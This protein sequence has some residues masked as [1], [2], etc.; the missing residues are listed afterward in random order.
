MNQIY[1]TAEGYVLPCC[2]IGNE[3]DM[4]EY[5]KWHG[6][7]L[8]EMSLKNRN[9]EDILKDPRYLRIEKSWERAEPFAPCRWNC[10][11][12]L[13][14]SWEKTQGTNERCSLILGEIEKAKVLER[15]S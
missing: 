7:D 13:N 12:P 8:E 1:V 9:L 10:S 4:K 6:D 15:R 5:R 2:W 11:Q 14:R 3:P